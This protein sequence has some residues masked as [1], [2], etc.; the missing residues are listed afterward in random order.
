MYDENA[1]HTA[2][3]VAWEHQQTGHTIDGVGWAKKR[4]NG[5]FKME[6]EPAN[7]T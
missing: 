6:A 4:L 3:K 7:E 1:T 2:I 5:Q